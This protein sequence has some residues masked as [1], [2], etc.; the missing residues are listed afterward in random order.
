M[1]FALTLFILLLIAGTVQFW[2]K[3]AIAGVFLAFHL[4]VLFGVIGIMTWLCYRV[5]G[6]WAFLVVPGAWVLFYLRTRPRSV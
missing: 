2:F 3:Y 4:L 6:S 1:T 5:I